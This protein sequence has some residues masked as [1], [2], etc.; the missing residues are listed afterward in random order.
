MAGIC[1]ITNFPD[2]C[3]DLCVHLHTFHFFLS[4]LI[5]LVTDK[6]K[7]KIKC[8]LTFCTLRLVPSNLQ[9]LHNYADAFHSTSGQR[10]ETQSCVQ[11]QKP[12]PGRALTCP[13]T[14]FS[15]L[16]NQLLYE[17]KTEKKFWKESECKKFYPSY[18]LTYSAT[19][20]IC[21][22]PLNNMKKSHFSSQIYF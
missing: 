12:E 4:L 15:L 19:I 14:L 21:A 2:F 20:Y 5:P 1:A 18:Q 17:R 16:F 10:T 8:K 11:F 3:M 9:V 7:M 22:F 13:A 6:K